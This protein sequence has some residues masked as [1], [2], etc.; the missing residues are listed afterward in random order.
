MLVKTSTV[1]GY[2]IVLL[3]AASAVGLQGC[4]SDGVE[5]N[6]KIFEMVGLAGDQ[7]AKREPKTQARAPL[8]LPPD[9]NKLPEPGAEQ[10]PVV[11]G[12]VADWPRDREAAKSKD[13]DARRAAHKKYCED[14]NWKEKAHKKDI[15]AAQGPDGSCSGSLFSQVGKFLQGE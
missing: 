14:G 3:V 8:V 4:A 2:A 7:S 6:G 1:R 5:F 10:A 11:T 12:S 9:A 15:E 13:A